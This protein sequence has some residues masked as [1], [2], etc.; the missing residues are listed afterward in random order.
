MVDGFEHIIAG[1]GGPVE[2]IHIVLSRIMDILFQFHGCVF[3]ICHLD[4]PQNV[5]LQRFVNDLSNAI[6]LCC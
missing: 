3:L 1:E 2:K 4:N 6:G 5:Q